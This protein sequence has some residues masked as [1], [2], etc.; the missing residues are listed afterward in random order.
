MLKYTTIERYLKYHVM[1]F[2]RMFSVKFP[3]AS[4]ACGRH[5]ET[6]TSIMDADG[7]V[8]FLPV[9][10]SKQHDLYFTRFKLSWIDFSF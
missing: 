3:A 10:V 4:I 7:V 1:E 9:L 6:S 8:S 5:V 2:E